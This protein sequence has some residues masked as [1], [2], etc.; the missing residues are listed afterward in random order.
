MAKQS[1][2]RRFPND[3]EPGYSGRRRSKKRQRR[4]P[5]PTETVPEGLAK[6]LS[7]RYSGKS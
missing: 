2:V 1:R 3:K 7:L 5:K 4:W 6:G